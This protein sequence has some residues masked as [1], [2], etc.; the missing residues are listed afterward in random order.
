MKAIIV[1][2]FGAPEVLK[3]EDAAKPSPGLGQILVK[4]RAAGVNP[5]DIYMRSGNYARKPALPY[6]P[7]V[8]GAG[9]VD[10]VGAN[11]TRFKPGDR[12]YLAGSVTGTYAEYAL[13][14]ATDAYTLPKSLTFA[15]GAAVHIPYAT[16]YRSLFQLAHA[17][18][19]EW[20]LV[21]GASGG[22][23]VASIQFARAIGMRIIGTGGTDRGREL[24]AKEGAHHV[25]DHRAPDLAARVMEI[26]G[27]NGADVILEMLANV[28][29][30]ADL[31]MLAM[32]GRVVIIGSRGDVQITPRD[33]MAREAAVLGV[34][35]WNVQPD[36]MA[37][38]H[39]A[40]GAGLENGSLRPIVGKEL[41]LAEAPRAHKEVLEPG[42]YGKIVL[43]P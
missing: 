21:H 29:L 37:A 5:A 27:N 32:R 30:G 42:A 24:V 35:L 38:I 10:S 41:P 36:E 2:E 18:P 15:Q 28:N 26:T 9:E 4:V 40:V 6:T 13:V 3:L 16:A 14:N 33:I 8:D 19:N 34:L 12:V 11:V 31:K 17:R 7:G 39:A 20:L 43:V 1:R 22:V 25:L 23:G